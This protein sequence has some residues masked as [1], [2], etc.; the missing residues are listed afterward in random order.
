MARALKMGYERPG[1][2]EAKEA[3]YAWILNI[4]VR[5]KQTQKDVVQPNFTA[6]SFKRQGRKH[7]N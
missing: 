3:V 7:Q 6:T 1:S 2:S 4:E 5:V